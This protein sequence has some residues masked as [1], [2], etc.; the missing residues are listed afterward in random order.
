[1]FDVLYYPLEGPDKE[2]NRVVGVV[3]VLRDVTDSEN[4][5]H[6]LR[7]VDR[8]LQ[9][10]LRNAMTVV[11][12]RAQQIADT[13]GEREAAADEGAAAGDVDSVA[14]GAADIAARAEALLSTSEKVHQITEVLSDPPETEPVDVARAVEAV[15]AEIADAFPEASVTV[16]T[17]DGTVHA[18]ATTW[19]DRAIDELVRNAIVHHDRESPTVGSRS[20]RLRIR[21]RSPSRT[22]DRG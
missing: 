7:V 14:A 21:S 19:I 20:P 10:N 15:A 13:A 18:S 5:A 11:R 2:D 16:S 1:M 17:P 6:Q 3:G 4:R 12:G 22:T 8:V 9:H